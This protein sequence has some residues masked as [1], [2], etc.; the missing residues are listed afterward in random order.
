MGTP[1]SASHFV[2]ITAR[3][4]DGAVNMNQLTYVTRSKI[5]NIASVLVSE[6]SN[7]DM[8]RNPEAGYENYAPR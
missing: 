5:V 3:K 7:H 6:N 2:E 1:F 4:R 8:L